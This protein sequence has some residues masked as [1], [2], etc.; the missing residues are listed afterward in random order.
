MKKI[1]SLILCICLIFGCSSCTSKQERAFE[2]EAAAVF[3]KYQNV[4]EDGKSKKKFVY[5]ENG[6]YA[7][8]LALTDSPADKDIKAY[9][10]GVVDDFKKTRKQGDKLFISYR[11]Y[12]ANKNVGTV[13]VISTRQSGNNKTESIK[14]FNY[15]KVSADPVSADLKKAVEAHAQREGKSVAADAAYTFKKDG[16]HVGD[17]VIDYNKIYHTLPSGLKETVNPD[18]HVVDLSKKLVAITYDDGP[19]EFTDDILD[20]YAEHGQVATFF[21]Q[22]YLSP[23]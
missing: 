14:V 13:E 1:I 23:D 12:A 17:Y 8:E 22:G 7:V 9:C 3:K 6:S 21:E 5:D 18:T 11:Q 16:L 4:R 2:N 19:C 15:D 20:I 10:D